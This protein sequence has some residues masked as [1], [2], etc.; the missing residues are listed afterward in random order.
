MRKYVT[1]LGSFCTDIGRFNEAE[2]LYN[3]ATEL[4][5]ENAGLYF[6]EFAMAYFMRAPVIMEKF[7]DDTAHIGLPI[8]LGLLPL[9]SWR[10]AEFLNDN[11]PGMN[12]PE[13]IRARMKA[14]GKGD[15]A[16]AE[17]VR[18]AQ[19]RRDEI[20]GIVPA[21]DAPVYGSPKSLVRLHQKV[22]NA[23]E[24]LLW[25]VFSE[26]HCHCVLRRMPLYHSPA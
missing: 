17:G 1:T 15:A 19:E 7:L 13:E 23:Q 3:R 26:P 10:N 25:I 22:A 9:A 11:V 14:A 21:L 4:D 24:I 16:R 8:L 20:V 12:V 5:E 18:I 2:E 6:T